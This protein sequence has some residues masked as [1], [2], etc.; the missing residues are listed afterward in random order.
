M[1]V[2][3]E[4][5]RLG[6]AE[7]SHDNP[8]VNALGQEHGGGGVPCVVET[9][10]RD[11]STLKEALPS[12]AVDGEVHG[13]PVRAGEDEVV[14]VPDRS[15]REPVGGLLAVVVP[16]LLDERSG[17]GD[18][19]AAGSGL[20]VFEGPATTMASRASGGG[21]VGAALAAAVVPGAALELTTHAELTGVEVDVRPLQP[22]A[23]TLAKTQ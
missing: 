10:H 12:L 7:Q 2:P 5:G 18:G 20:N 16:Q 21:V 4:E 1:L 17:Q 3:S 19:A 13:L 8:A 14:V 11:L 22:E 15:G 6:P 23:L 9:E